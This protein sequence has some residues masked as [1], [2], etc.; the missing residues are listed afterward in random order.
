MQ[1]LP[2]GSALC[3]LAEGGQSRSDEERMQKTKKN[4]NNKKE[5]ATQ[6]QGKSKATQNMEIKSCA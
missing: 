4:N 1:N 6:R 5:E 2:E 3:S